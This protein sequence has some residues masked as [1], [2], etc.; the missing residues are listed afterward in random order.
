VMTLRVTVTDTTAAEDSTVTLGPVRLVLGQDPEL[1][2][3]PICRTPRGRT[4][5]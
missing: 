4:T 2:P 5:N 1:F 3:C